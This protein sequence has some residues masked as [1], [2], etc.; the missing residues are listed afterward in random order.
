MTAMK[1]EGLRLDG[2]VAILERTLRRGV[3]FL[4]AA[5]LSGGLY[6][7]VSSGQPA[8]PPAGESAQRSPAAAPLDHVARSTPIVKA[9][10]EIPVGSPVYALDDAAGAKDWL[11][12]SLIQLISVQ[13][14]VWNVGV[15]AGYSVFRIYPYLAAGSPQPRVYQGVVVKVNGDL[16]VDDLKAAIR[17]RR[18]SIK[19]DEYDVFGDGSVAVH[20]HSRPTAASP[21]VKPNG[22][23]TE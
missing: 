18:T 9:W 5:C 6:I 4:V 1:D 2:G 23:R 11:E 17:E 21:L 22:T 13:T 10:R 19:I 7:G 20:R 14:G 16:S 8:K 15:E 12:N 3:A